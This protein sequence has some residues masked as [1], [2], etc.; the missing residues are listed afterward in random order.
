MLHSLQARQHAV[1]PAPARSSAGEA[2][3]DLLGLVLRLH[4]SFITAGEALARPAGQTL[5]RWV[6]LDQCRNAALSVSD[7]A[8]RLGLARQ[9]VQRV[10]DLLV[11]DRLC[12]YRENPH[13]QRA[14]LLDLNQ[15]GR[16]ALTAIDTAQ[17]H[18]CDTLGAA[19]GETALRR[20]AA[21]LRAVITAVERSGPS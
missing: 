4:R 17:H 11:A 13:H 10:A 21:G 15:T 12:I 3:N 5:A 6:V 2:F 18:W 19:I 16:A 1:K 20:T 8:R 9:S 14:K 7:I